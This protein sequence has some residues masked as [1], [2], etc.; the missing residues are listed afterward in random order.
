M[1][2]ERNSLVVL[3]RQKMSA[4]VS[5]GL[6]NGLEKNRRTILFNEFC[7]YSKSRCSSSS[8]GLFQSGPEVSFHVFNRL[9]ND[10]LTIAR[11][12]ER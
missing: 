9:Q 6:Q 1:Q 10:E 8:L 12:L 11:R 5:N 4:G 2:L 7:F 3:V